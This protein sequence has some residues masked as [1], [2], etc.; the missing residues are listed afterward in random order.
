MGGKYILEIRFRRKREVV[1]DN[2]SEVLLRQQFYWHTQYKVVFRK[3]YN[4]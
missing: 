2:K 3:S 1:H 4:S